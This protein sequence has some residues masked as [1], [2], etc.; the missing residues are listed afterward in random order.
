MDNSLEKDP[1]Q[2]KTP[3]SFLEKAACVVNGPV[4]GLLPPRVQVRLGEATGNSYRA[5][6]LMSLSSRLTNIGIG[7]YGVGCVASRLFGADIDLT[8][9][10]AIT[11]V[12]IPIAFD[13]FLRE[14]MNAWE[15]TA[16]GGN[17]FRDYNVPWGEPFLS[18]LDDRI[19]SK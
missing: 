9:M 1:E 10:D 17:L 14:F 3:L 6:T 4:L 18:V 7:L 2:N 16:A 15:Y 12:G 19:N 13:S 11:W 5:A 8:P